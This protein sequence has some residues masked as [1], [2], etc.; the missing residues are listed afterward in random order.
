MLVLETVGEIDPMRFHALPSGIQAQWRGYVLGKLRGTFTSPAAPVSQAV[1]LA[2]I[3]HNRTT[4][5]TLTLDE[6]RAR[7]GGE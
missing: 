5:E 1:A 6:F 4:G 2:W 3:E 7:M